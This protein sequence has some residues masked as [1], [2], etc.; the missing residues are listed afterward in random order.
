MTRVLVKGQVTMMEKTAVEEWCI[1]SV[2][3]ETVQTVGYFWAIDEE[4]A[5]SEAIKR[6]GPVGRDQLV[7]HRVPQPSPQK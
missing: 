1:L 5:I 3:G 7:A 4:A 6:F 2:V